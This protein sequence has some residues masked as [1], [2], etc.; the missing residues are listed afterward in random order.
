MISFVGLFFSLFNLYLYFFLFLLD[1]VTEGGERNISIF[2]K[3]FFKSA[4]CDKKKKTKKKKKTLLV[5]GSDLFLFTGIRARA[6][7][8]SAPQKKV[9][10]PS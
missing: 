10:T 4:K 2:I 3:T 5:K 1:Y 9:M 7:S 6:D 8:F